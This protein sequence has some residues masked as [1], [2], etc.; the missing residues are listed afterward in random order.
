ME[1]GTSGQET[2]ALTLQGFLAK[3]V[4]T[5]AVDPER[6]LAYL[7]YLGFEGS[8]APLF[9]ISKLRRQERNVQQLQRNVIQACF[10]YLYPVTL[11]VVRPP[12]G[13]HLGQCSEC[14][15]GH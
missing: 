14:H 7:R 8:A 5:A 3:W 13:R 9:R 11:P 4:Y 1:V 2:D 15:A 10:P 12:S 6:T